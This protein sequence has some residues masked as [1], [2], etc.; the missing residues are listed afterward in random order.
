[1]DPKYRALAARRRSRASSSAR[2]EAMAKARKDN[3]LD[4]DAPLE[5]LQALDRYTLQHQAEGAVLQLHLQPRRLPRLLRR[6]ARGDRALRRRRRR[7]HPVGTG[8]YRVA[9]W[10]RASK[11]RLR[12]QPQLSA[13]STSTT[14]RAAGRRR[15]PG[16]PRRRR[17]ASACRS[18]GAS[19]STSSRQTQPRWLAFLNERA[20]P[21]LPRSR[22]VRQR[23]DAREQARAQPAQARHRAWAQMPG[24]R[25]HVQLLQ[26]G[27]PGRRR[28]HAGEGRAAPRDLA[29]LQDRTTRSPIMRKGQAIPAHTPYSPGVAG[30]DPNFRTTRQRVQ[31]GQ[32]EGAA[33]HVRLR[34]PRRRR[35]PRDAR[36][37]PARAAAPTRRPP[38]A[39]SSWTSCGSAA[40][41]TS[42]SAITVR[43]AK[44]PDLLKESNAGK[45]QFW[46]LGGSASSP[47]ADTWL[48][49]LYGPERRL[50]GQPRALP[51]RG[52]RPPLREGA[53][54]ARLARAHEDLP[55]DGQAGGRVRAVEDQHAPHP[56]RPLASVGAAATAARPCRAR[57]SGSTSTSIRRGKPRR[58]D[59]HP[60]RSERLEAL[61]SCEHAP[62]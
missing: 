54:H 51:P 18:S 6:G 59:S 55:G 53:R 58:G 3:Q 60:P 62:V 47:D 25:P 9:F 42:A 37:Q 19:R 4:Y 2:D 17:R 44:W 38:R 8:P 21:P 1:M 48:T 56:H 35:L 28:L 20:R 24:A 29:R 34:G 61:R 33:R 13:R 14:S 43:K 15:G 27:G 52:L 32:G 46:Q 45:L 7:S 30:Y 16:D 11:H 12:G 23:R 57:T 31:P 39:T 26:H 5:G 10:K 41:T 40:W 50:Q 49:S 36:R 22:G